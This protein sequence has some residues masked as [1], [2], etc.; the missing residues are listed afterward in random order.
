MKIKSFSK[1]LLGLTTG[2]LK[3]EIEYDDDAQVEIVS[4]FYGYSR[5]L[6]LGPSFSL[7]S[8]KFANKQYIESDE[9][10]PRGN[11]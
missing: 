10:Y 1:G 11:N 5:C 9:R 8:T 3:R 7:I 4:A 6:G 2:C